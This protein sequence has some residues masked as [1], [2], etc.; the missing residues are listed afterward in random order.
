MMEAS[1]RIRTV[2][3]VLAV[4][5][6]IIAVIY[7]IIALIP[8]C[9]AYDQGCYDPAL[10]SLPVAG[11]LAVVFVLLAVAISALSEYLGW[12][13]ALRALEHLPEGEVNITP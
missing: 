7:L 10:Y 13:G 9:P 2:G 5:A 12:S 8:T 6:A 4:V 1:V 3:S 11:P